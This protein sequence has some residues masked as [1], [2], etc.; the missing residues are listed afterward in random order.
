[1]YIYI[2][3][4]VI[5]SRYRAQGGPRGA[6]APR[7]SPWAPIKISRYPLPFRDILSPYPG[8]GE[9]R[10]SPGLPSLGYMQHLE[11]TPER[12][13]GYAAAAAW[14]SAPLRA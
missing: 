5:G 11:P 6:S 13:Y 2:Y 9:F 4:S 3:T 7:G 10:V 14:E 8:G 12:S 1:M